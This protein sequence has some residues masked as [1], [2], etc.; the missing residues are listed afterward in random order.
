MVR[1]VRVTPAAQE[2]FTPSERESAVRDYMERGPGYFVRET[3]FVVYR[4]R[5]GRRLVL[6]ESGGFVTLMTWAD[7][8]AYRRNR[9][10]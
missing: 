7:L 6:V 8:M 5:D 4:S 10:S 2:Q 1:E 3:G 9:R